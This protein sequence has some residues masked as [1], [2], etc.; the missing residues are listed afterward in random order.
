MRRRLEVH[1]GD[2]TPAPTQLLRSTFSPHRS[3]LSLEGVSSYLTPGA[4]TL[5]GV[6]VVAWWLCPAA[7][8]IN[9]RLA[10]CATSKAIYG[11]LHP[12]IPMPVPTMVKAIV[13][14][15]VT[16][17]F[18]Q[19]IGRASMSFCELSDSGSSDAETDT[20]ESG[21]VSC[22]SSACTECVIANGDTM[23]TSK[24]GPEKTLESPLSSE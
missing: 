20:C 11:C 2:S 18:E 13:T 3:I 15:K 17:F 1:D 10:T 23:G 12:W 5:T 22:K 6:P 9:L 7:A 14:P 24:P 4:A 8:I 16:A 21:T 19:N